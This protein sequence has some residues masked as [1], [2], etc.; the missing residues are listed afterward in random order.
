MNI[1]ASALV[2][3]LVMNR[4]TH[5][6]DELAT[7]FWDNMPS[8]QARKNLR[9]ILPCL[10]TVLDTYFII[11]H[12]TITFNTHTAFWLDVAVFC[13]LL[14]PPLDSVATEYLWEA[15]GL[16]QGDFLQGFGVRHA[17]RFEEWM[18][19]ERE[20]LRAMMIDALT[21]LANRHTRQHDYQQGIIATRHLL[22]LEPWNETAHQQQMVLLALQGRR[23]LAQT[24]YDVCSRILETEFGLHPLPETTALH[25][26][27][28]AGDL[29]KASA[30]VARGKIEETTE[31][32]TL[33]P[34]V[35][36]HTPAEGS[37]PSPA[38]PFTH[39]CITPDGRLLAG[40]AHCQTITLWNIQSG[41]VAAI[42]EGHD[43]PVTALVVSA[44]GILASGSSD[45]AIL[46]WDVRKVGMQH[47]VP[48]SYH[49]LPGH[50]VGITALAFTPDG[51]GLASGSSD[52]SLALWDV[53]TGTLQ[54]K[55][56]GHTAVIT[57]VT[58]S[59]AQDTLISGSSNNHAQEVRV[60]SLQTGRCLSL[61]DFGEA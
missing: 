44:D 59:P 21:T 19:L 20:R 52:G 29:R 55:L 60:W 26:A 48:L 42:L 58:F 16:Y 7:L 6:R 4:R 43:A 41:R 17:P 40:S 1:R 53:A 46:L 15:V 3:Y 27:I 2:Y 30:M 25:Q 23:D 49:R 45:G 24:Q 56:N 47:A 8:V 39:M 22:E 11:T 14:S 13:R 12:H 32:S 54:H 36:H 28:Q 51:S 5:S 33:I 31:I 37:S 50:S 34:P 38:V 10:R 9:N 18:L 57:T 61:F 35:E